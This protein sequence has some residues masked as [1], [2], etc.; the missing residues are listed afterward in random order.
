M[1]GRPLVREA[2]GGRYRLNPSFAREMVEVQ[3]FNLWDPKDDRRVQ[4]PQVGHDHRPRLVYRLQR[5]HG[6]LPGG[7]QHSAGRQGRRLRKREMHWI[8]IDRYYS[9]K[10]ST[11]A[12]YACSPS[13]ASNAR[14]RPASSSARS[15]RPSTA[16]KA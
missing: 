12:P 11:D 13:G 7:E 9:G 10:R 14:T 6:G 2:T 16:P 3:R 15:R 1:E 4:G 8:R 5:L